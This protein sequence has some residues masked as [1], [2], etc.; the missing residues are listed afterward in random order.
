[1]QP[2][3][4]EIG[5][6]KFCILAALKTSLEYLVIQPADRY[7]DDDLFLLAFDVFAV[8]IRYW[9]NQSKQEAIPDLTLQ[10]RGVELCGAESIAISLDK[11]GRALG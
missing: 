1:M 11:L 3:R 7:E 5:A 4:F 6:K 2:R 9:A 8:S 10:S